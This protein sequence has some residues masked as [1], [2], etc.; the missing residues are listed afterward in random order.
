MTNAGGPPER[1]HQG[2][3]MGTINLLH[4]CVVP[5]YQLLSVRLLPDLINAFFGGNHTDV[6]ITEQNSNTGSGGAVRLV[7]K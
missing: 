1:A 4:A 6:N 5:T 7:G 2:R 3:S